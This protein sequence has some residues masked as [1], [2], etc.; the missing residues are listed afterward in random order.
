MALTRPLR[1]LLAVGVT[2]V[3]LAAPLVAPSGRQPTAVGQTPGVKPYG[4]EVVIGADHEPPGLNPLLP[5][6]DAFVL[7]RIGQATWCGVQDIDGSTREL[8]PDVVTT[9]PSVANGGLRVNS[10]GTL[11]VRY[12][13]RP[14]ASWADGVAVSG[15][16]FEFTYETIMRPDLPTDKSVY[17]DIIPSSL[18]SGPKTFEYTLRTPTLQ[19][20][21]LFDVILPKHDVSGTDFAADYNDAMWTSCGPFEFDSWAKGDR[22]TLVRNDHYWKTDAETG[23][24]LPYLNRVVFRFITPTSSLTTAFKSRQVDVIHVPPDVAMIQD[25]KQ[26]EAQGAVIE[27]LAGPIWEHLNFQFGENRLTRNPDSLNDQLLYRQAVAHAIDKHRIVDEVL[28]GLVAPFDSYIEAYTP[29]LSTSAWA[30]YDYS[31]AKARELI[32]RLGRGTPTVVFS[33]TSNNDARVRLSQLLQPMFHLAGMEYE[34]DLEDSSIFFGETLDF[35]NW[36]LGE[37]AWVG[38]PGL[39]GLVGTHDVFDPE[40]PP[41]DGQNFYRWGTPAVSGASPGGFNQGPSS[42][43]DAHTNRFAVLRDEMNTTVDER[44]LVP[45][46]QEAEHILADQAVIIPLYGRPDPGAVW[47]DEIAGYKHNPSQ[48]GDTWNIEEWYRADREPPPGDRDGDGVPDASDECPDGAEDHD[49]ERDENGCIDQLIIL[50]AQLEGATLPPG[51]VEGIVDPGDGLIRRLQSYYSK[52]SYA[53]IALTPVSG[54][55]VVDLPRTMSSYVMAERYSNGCPSGAGRSV[56]EYSL[57]KDVIQAGLGRDPDRDEAVPDS[58]VAVVYPTGSCQKEQQEDRPS[59]V[60]FPSVLW[61]QPN[62]HVVLMS[63]RDDVGGWAHE[64][65][66]A[67]GELEIDRGYTATPHPPGPPTPNGDPDLTTVGCWDVMAHGV[68]NGS[69]GREDCLA[70]DQTRPPH[71]ASF[72]KELLGWLRYESFG[73][74]DLQ[75]TTSLASL[76]HGDAIKR[77]HVRGGD[78]ERELIFEL[79]DLSRAATTW[80]WA[81]HDALVVWDVERSPDNPHLHENWIINRAAVFESCPASTE[82]WTFGAVLTIRCELMGRPF[83]DLVATFKVDVSSLLDISDPHVGMVM[84]PSGASLSAPDEIAPT[85]PTPGLAPDLDL[86]AWTTDGRH[87][88]VDYATGEFDVEVDGARVSGDRLNGVEWIVLPAD[89][90][91]VRFRV[92]SRDTRAAVA[93]APGGFAELGGAETYRI[94]GVVANPG[95]A[96]RFSMPLAGVALLGHD[97]VYVL[98]PNGDVQALSLGDEVGLAEPSQGKWHLRSAAGL[99]KTFFYGNP[100]DTPFVGDWDC[101][102]VDTPGL[103]RQSDGFVY[104]R[105][106]NTAGIADIRF[107]FGNP[108]DVPAVGD[109]DGDGCDTVSIYRPSEQRFYVVNKLGEDGGGLGAAESFFAFGNPGDRPVVG[110]WDGDGIDEAGLHRE[111]TGLFYWRDTLTTGNAKG[112]ILFGNP[113]DAFIAGD[114]GI[115]D[116]ADTPAVFRPSDATFYFR[117]TLTQGSAD[118]Q[119]SF[120]SGAW[121]PVAGSFGF[122]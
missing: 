86:H 103:Y 120:G 84:D 57:I 18:K 106:S 47:A 118:S 46:I 21:F 29:T 99:E 85:L 107:F 108:G 54:P 101:D 33:T 58:V 90:E 14:E 61:Q 104:L 87:V 62:W 50:V 60:Y 97:P 1:A 7:L 114:W 119:F 15:A 98:S 112:E 67:L 41:P 100:G 30:R 73:S 117:H 80:D 59:T 25:L 96:I 74:G 24:R 89:T 113:G 115:V 116:G 22:L 82:A 105:N 102:G 17:E 81:P 66:H 70:G 2:T 40:A 44:R 122:G 28:G 3:V 32:A 6:G 71:M 55:K 52:N 109:F 9:L 110:D 16:D 49:N 48:A 36:D 5:G 91:D 38:V 83:L 11:T 4:G 12:D 20:E 8:I 111:S 95:E 53:S 51:Y 93:A 75:V 34:A 78:A 26:L 63:V 10:D 94:Q 69:V 39:A 88:G 45:L 27:V 72:T 56:D 64:I 19:A 31:P 13:I 79:R 23:Q 76:K 65:G 42:V 121:L 92:S 77:F 68:W 35:G 37:F 43:I